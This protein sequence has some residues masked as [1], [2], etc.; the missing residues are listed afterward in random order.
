[1]KRKK[2]IV[3]DKDRAESQKLPVR[4]PTARPTVWHKDK[5][6]YDRRKE[7]DVEVC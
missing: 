6:D 1:M 5:T 2:K 3:V 4:I 7:Q